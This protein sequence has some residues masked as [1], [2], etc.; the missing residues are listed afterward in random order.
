VA[1][2]V[3]GRKHVLARVNLTIC[4]SDGTSPSPWDDSWSTAKVGL[5]EIGET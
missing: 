2:L 3:S 4:G 5:E 1:R